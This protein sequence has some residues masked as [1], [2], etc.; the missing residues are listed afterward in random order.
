MI[1]SKLNEVFVMKEAPSGDVNLNSIEFDVSDQTGDVA[2]RKRGEK[3][4][5]E[6]VRFIL[7][8]TKFKGNHVKVILELESH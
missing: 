4:L 1:M 8:N 6:A 5:I 7:T 2:E 3:G